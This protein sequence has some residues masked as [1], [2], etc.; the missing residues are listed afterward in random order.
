MRIASVRAEWAMDPAR[1]V[2]ASPGGANWTVC[3]DREVSLK[4][5]VQSRTVFLT[6]V[7]S[8]RDVLPLLSPKVQTVGMAFAERED[9]V[10]FAEAA[11]AAGV[12]RCVRPGL[13]NN[14]ESPWDGK[15]LLN[16]LRP[17]V[18]LK[19]LRTLKGSGTRSN[20]QT[21]LV[22]G[23]AGFIGSCFVRQCI[24]DTPPGSSIST[25]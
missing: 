10:A 9:A 18:I 12:A 1:D 14:Y 22:T 24:A 11:T 23:G 16:Q 13:M 4:E 7:P 17:W 25:S 5:A 15:L 21:I 3:M 8:W 6:E 19:A 20:M 2:L